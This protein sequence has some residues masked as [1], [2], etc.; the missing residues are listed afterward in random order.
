MLETRPDQVQTALSVIGIQPGDGLLVHS[1]LQFLGRPASGTGMY[2]DIL[3]DMLGMGGTLVVPTFNFGF[4][5]GTPYDPAETP[6]QGMGVFSEWVRIQPQSR[7][8]LHPLQSVAAIGQYAQD[9]AGRDTTSAFDPGSAFERMLDLDFKLLLLG[10]DIQA[11]SMIHY[12]EQR[13]AVPYRYWKDF[14][15]QVN[16]PGGWQVRT[17]RMF[18]RDMDI[19]PQLRLYPVQLELEH[20]GE[21][22][23]VPL[24]YGKLSTCSL[25]NFVQAVDDLLH[26]DAWVLVENRPQ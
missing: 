11:A 20:R 22:A 2:L 25:K 10:A 5:R 18:V 15:G 19:N 4:A 6:S 7:R 8:T 16:T 17:Y 1:A 14:T 26:Q 9:L 13:A 21:W 23:E 12:S 3:L 24:G